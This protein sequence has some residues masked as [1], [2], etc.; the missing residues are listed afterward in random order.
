MNRFNILLLAILFAISCTAQKKNRAKNN[1]KNS[2]TTETFTST[3]PDTKIGSKIPTFG[4][5][6]ADLNL[7]FDT[8]LDKNKSL[9]LVLFNPSCGHCEQLITNVRDS[10]YL[11]KN[12]EFLFVTGKELIEYVP[13]F[14]ERL[15][16]KNHELI[17]ISSDQSDL[18]QKLF[19]YN[20]I[21]QIMIYNKEKL[22]QKI[23]FKE[24]TMQQLLDALQ[25][26]NIEQKK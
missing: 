8:Y 3:K 14:A 22:L 19:E 10:S 2:T 24:A 15:K 11:F 26:K 7:T 1:L 23:L 4:V 17:T 18:T 6:K 20:G 12:V 16:V 5:L 9:V 25:T 21:P 13:D